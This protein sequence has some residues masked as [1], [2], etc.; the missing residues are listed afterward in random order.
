[1]RFVRKQRQRYAFPAVVVLGAAF[2]VAAG[3][4][5]TPP[6]DIPSYALDSAAIYKSE[7]GLALFFGVYLL[8]TA[9]ALAFE[10]RTRGKISTTGIELPG[11]ISASVLAQQ[12]LTEELERMQRDIT[13]GNGR[14]SRDVERLWGKVERL[15]SERN[16]RG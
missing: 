6:P 8:V 11:D 9:I 7:V 15:D 13:R 12:E 1:M 4:E 5:A 2:A 14:L 3:A 10:G 16:Q